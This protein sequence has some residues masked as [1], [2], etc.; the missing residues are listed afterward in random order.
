MT[1]FLSVNET[2]YLTLYGVGAIKT[3][4]DAPVTAIEK[5]LTDRLKATTGYIDMA[6]FYMEVPV[7]E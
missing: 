7:I 5:I 6:A 1:L 4:P 2:K 3:H